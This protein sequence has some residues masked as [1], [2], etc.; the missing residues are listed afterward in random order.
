MSKN[1]AL[2]L[3]S[4]AAASHPAFSDGLYVVVAHLQLTMLKVLIFRNSCV[5]DL[6]MLM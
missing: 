3:P 6:T 1:D 4:Q 2:K 5:P